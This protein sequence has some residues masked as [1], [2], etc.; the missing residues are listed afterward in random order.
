[1]PERAV[2]HMYTTLLLFS[3][4]AVAHSS[5]ELRFL[6]DANSNATGM[7]HTL[8][9]EYRMERQFADRRPASQNQ[10]QEYRWTKAGQRE[11]FTFIRHDVKPTLDGRP[12]GL[13]DVVL[14]GSKYQLLGNWDPKRPQRISPEQQGTVMAHMGPQTNVNPAGPSP[15]AHFLFAVDYPP[16]RSLAELVRVSRHAAV[17]G[18]ST[19]GGH[20]TW[21]IG[22]ESPEEGDRKTFFEIHLDPKV[23][24]MV[25]KVVK[26]KPM[27][28]RAN[29]KNVGITSTT[30]VV[31]FAEVKEG[32]FFPIQ[33]TGTSSSTPS[34]TVQTTVTSVRI[35]DPLP[36]DAFRIEFPKYALVEDYALADGKARVHIWGEAKPLATVTTQAE[37]DAFVD[38]LRADP[39]AAAELGLEPAGSA[40]IRRY[41]LWSAPVLLVLALVA[42]VWRRVRRG[43]RLS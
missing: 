1:M 31:R 40:G 14:D 39:K 34:A 15:A 38:Q 19:V 16:G 12:Q 9:L 21:V 3:G 6:V 37:I 35:N 11:R 30:E 20:Q 27:A 32:L 18:T 23:N 33:L 25:C 13:M 17:K 7:I 41:V 4:L 10:L 43:A 42:V 26:D 29:S 22:A 5:D 24:Y 2:A 28:K 8:D 36:D